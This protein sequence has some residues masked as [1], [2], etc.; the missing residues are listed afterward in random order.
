MEIINYA[1]EALTTKFATFSG[2]ARRRE[3]WLFFLFTCIVNVAINA[4]S[5]AVKD[6]T[7]FTIVVSIISIVW[8]LFIIIPSIAITVRR[9]HDTNRSGW[10]YLLSLAAACLLCASILLFVTNNDGPTAIVS[11]LL[12]IVGYITFFVFLVLPG[13]KGENDYG[14][15]PKAIADAPDSNNSQV[16]VKF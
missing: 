4:L 10:W 7:P 3:Y 8:G 15:D 6:S 2:R 5:L 13:T 14:P 1:R 9:L 16:E 12:G 11:L